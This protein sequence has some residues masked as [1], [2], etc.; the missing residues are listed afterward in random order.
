MCW[1]GGERSRNVALLLALVG[2][3]VVTVGGG[4]RA[5]RRE[6][7]SGLAEW[8]APMPVFTLYGHTGAGK[9]ALIRA[10]AEPALA[11]ESPARGGQA[12]GGRPGGAGPASG[13]AARRSEPTGRAASEGLRRSAV[14]RASPSGG[15]LSGA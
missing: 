7:L 1:R 8:R 4:Y 3:H 12:L 5:Y 15:R 14:G 13:V 2:V 11:A 10:L 9:S 6:V